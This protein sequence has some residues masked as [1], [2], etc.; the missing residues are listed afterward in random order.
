MVRGVPRGVFWVLLVI[1]LSA[2]GC[3]RKTMIVP[4]QT[5]VPVPVDDLEFS[6]TD[7]GVD[8]RWSFPRETVAGTRL[9]QIDGFE[10]LRAEI[11]AEDYCAGCPQPFG[12]PVEIRGG[13]LPDDGSGRTASFADSPLRPGYHYVYKVR[14]RS[15]KWGTSQDSNRVD[16]DWNPPGSTPAPQP[17]AHKP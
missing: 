3:G 17:P 16:F 8:L 15:G 4:P 14:A 12:P 6:I 2:V 5:L 10:L 11:P 7:T 9:K 1:V 13:T